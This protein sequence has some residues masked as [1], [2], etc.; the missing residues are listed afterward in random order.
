MESESAELDPEGIIHEADTAAARDAVGLLIPAKV[1]AY[2]GERDRCAHRIGA[3]EVFLIEP[4]TISQGGSAI[5]VSILASV[6]FS[7]SSDGALLSLWKNL[8]LLRRRHPRLA[9]GPVR[10]SVGQG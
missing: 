10:R 3:G 5:C 4:V 1:T 8:L 7:G 6:G 2:S 9:A